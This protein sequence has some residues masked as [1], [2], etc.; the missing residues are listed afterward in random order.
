M[1]VSPGERPSRLDRS[2]KASEPALGESYGST[3]ACHQARPAIKL[4][5]VSIDLDVRRSG[6]CKAPLYWARHSSAALHRLSRTRVVRTRAA[7][8]GAPEGQEILCYARPGNC[9]PFARKVEAKAACISVRRR[10]LPIMGRPVPSSGLR[11]SSGLG[12]VTE[13]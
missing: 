3:S 5:T 11:P 7:P 9:V 2:K 12:D 1:A 6:I 4:I 13:T 8:I 10:L